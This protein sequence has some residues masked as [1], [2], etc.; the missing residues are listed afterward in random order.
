MGIDTIDVYLLHRPDL[1]MDPAEVAGAFEQLRRQGKAKEFGVSNFTPSFTA[2]LASFCPMPLV[3]HQVEVH[4]GRLECLYDGTLDQ[5]LQRGMTPMAWSPLGGGWL[6]TGKIDPADPRAAIKRKLLETLDAI[7]KA[8]DSSR[9]VI[10]LAWLLK[11]PSRMVPIIG[12]NKPE[13]IRAATEADAIDLSR[14]DWY[15]LLTAAQGRRVAVGHITRRGNARI[16][17]TVT[18]ISASDIGLPLAPSRKN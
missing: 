9:T 8:Y 1:L 11:H 7:A 10:A 15:R 12:S 2:T 18:D 17:G 4:L 5:C 16:V 13:H 6:G 14:E 3:T